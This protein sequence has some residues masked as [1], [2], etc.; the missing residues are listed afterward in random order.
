LILKAAPS[1]YTT[2]DPG[3]DSGATASQEATGWCQVQRTSIITSSRGS[4][5]ADQ[6]KMSSFAIIS[7][8]RIRRGKEGQTRVEELG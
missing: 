5:H 6:S 7:S 8:M 2:P 3:T 1:N 4:T